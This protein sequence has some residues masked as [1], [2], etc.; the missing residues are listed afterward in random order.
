[1][2][3]I[4]KLLIL[5]IVYIAVGYL[6]KVVWDYFSY[7]YGFESIPLHIAIYILLVLSFIK[8]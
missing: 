2:N 7:I 8:F 5:V 1:M 4:E 3:E 6:F